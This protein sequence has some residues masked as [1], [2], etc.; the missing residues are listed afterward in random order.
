M[1][2]SPLF[3]QIACLF[4]SWSLVVTPVFAASGKQADAPKADPSKPDI[5]AKSSNPARSADPAKLQRNLNAYFD[6]LKAARKEIDRSSFDLDALTEKLDFDEQ[7]IIQFVQKEIAIELYPGVLRGAR[8]TLMSR[9]GNALDQSLLLATLLKNAGADARILR[10]ELN[11]EWAKKLVDTLQPTK[12]AELSAGERSRIQAHFVR[13]AKTATGKDM[14][15][16][17]LQQLNGPLVPLKSSPLF[18]SAT[19]S[20]QFIHDQLKKGDI[21][22]SAAIAPADAMM[23]KEA[24]DY[25]WVEYRK[26]PADAWAAVH[27]VFT[28]EVGKLLSLKASETFK[29][30]IPE[31]LQQTLEISVAIQQRIQGKI[32][33]KPVMAAWKRPVSNFYGEPL[34]FVNMPISAPAPN[35]PAKTGDWFKTATTFVPSL[36]QSA[37]PGAV[38]F[39]MSGQTVSQEDAASAYAAV[40]KT[41]GDKANK[42]AGALAGIG[43]APATDGKPAASRAM[44][45]EGQTLRLKLSAPGR[46]SVSYSRTIANRTDGFSATGHVTLPKRA[47]DDT[48][49]ALSL[50]SQYTIMVGAG[51]VPE[52]YLLDRI[53]ERMLAFEAMIRQVAAPDFGKASAKRNN[54]PADWSGFLPL[55]VLLDSYPLPDRV[56]SFRPQPSIIL[57]N[58]QLSTDGG[59]LERIDIVRN[60]RMVLDRQNTGLR[61]RPDLNMALGVWDT[62]MER[63]AITDRVPSESFN[64]IDAFDKAMK[65]GQRVSLIVDQQAL[66]GYKSQLPA[67]TLRAIQ[68]DL[69]DGY[70]VFLPDPE[71]SKFSENIAWWR[72]NSR[73]GE[74][75]GMGGDGRGSEIAKYFTLANFIALG[76]I[77]EVVGMCIGAAQKQLGKNKVRSCIGFGIGIGSIYPPLAFPFWVAGG[78]L[79]LVDVIFF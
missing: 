41:V 59:F 24:R 49:M 72:V 7:K 79:G 56:M 55:L 29:D 8:G 21:S 77:G 66:S 3:K 28:P 13:F 10:G 75:I 23:A 31:S 38:A 36:N 17:E 34:T 26:G 12:A 42:A 67:A 74:A 51:H 18:K 37:S 63:H 60:A 45:L 47:F 57:H 30:S 76:L 71:L 53:L 32:T 54:V 69:N 62:Y 40:I 68:R 61:T 44:E 9:A 73:T 50:T 65:T 22:L 20:A 16:D 46:P 19:K 78:V 35:D 1:G 33:D 39:D 70:L 2:N 48:D 6:T 15:W 4:V 58:Q 14:S 5:S 11:P 52:S 25:F 43:S 64:A 27:P